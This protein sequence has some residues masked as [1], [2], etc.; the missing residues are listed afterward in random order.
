MAIKM[1]KHFVLLAMLLM[2]MLMGYSQ[3]LQTGNPSLVMVSAERLKGI[4]G[5]IQQYIDSGWIN[6]ATAIIARKGKIVYHKSLGYDDITT[7]K[8]L[9]KDAIF[10]IASQTKA[11]TSVAVMM[12]YEEGKFLLDDAISKYIPEFKNPVVL[13]SFFTADSTFTTKPAKSQITIRQLLTHTSGIG[14][15][16]IG[17]MPFSAIYAKAGLIAGIGIDGHL[18]SED[19]K[20]LG[21]LPL[22]HQP[23]EKFT[24]GLNTDILGYLVERLSGQPLNV[25]LHKRIFEPLAM[26]DTYFYLPPDKKNRLATLYTTDEKKQL[27]KADT[28]MN[29]NGAFKTNYPLMKGN[30]FSGGG[31]LAST[32]KDFAIFMQ[33]LLNNG[34]YNGKRILSRN[35]IRIMTANQIGDLRMGH[36]NYFGLG[37]EIV[38]EKG[39]AHSPLQQGSFMWGG[40]FSSSYWI[41]PKE[42]II[43][44]LFLQ[45]FPNPH[46]NI[47]EKFKILTYQALTD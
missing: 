29:I 36:G 6:G 24:Y 42:Q 39:S 46:S 28:T 31:G 23:G 11:I 5:L 3:V 19:M 41:D 30:Y 7:N 47:H 2:N 45:L 1:H 27:Q 26:N 20:K 25:F 44:Q 8:P 4:D 12:L 33:M 37:F 17:S 22:V 35:T 10:R 40:M 13:D 32:A 43:G 38:S 18:L 21:A 16:Q 15:A 9:Y 34:I 14:Y